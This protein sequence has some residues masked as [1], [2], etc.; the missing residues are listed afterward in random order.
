M[1][2]GSSRYRSI[3]QW[4]GILPHACLHY[5]LPNLSKFSAHLSQTYSPSC[6]SRVLSPSSHVSRVPDC[7]GAFAFTVFDRDYR[8]CTGT[9]RLVRTR[10][11]AIEACWAVSPARDH[12][13]RWAFR[14]AWMICGRSSQ[15]KGEDRQPPTA[16]LPWWHLRR[17]LP[18]TGRTANTVS[19]RRPHEL[20]TTSLGAFLMR[21]S[22]HAFFWQDR[23]ASLFGGKETL[24][25]Q[26]CLP[27]VTSHDTRQFGM[28]YT[29]LR[30]KAAHGRVQ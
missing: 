13:G 23:S 24:C 29:V 9:H 7:P 11:Q 16:T 15:A 12:P 5:S 19:A 28:L 20:Y 21:F 14:E 22:Y 8:G 27:F 30:D 6:R 25:L 17:A 26:G 2:S 4:V 18:R 1:I 3:G 10:R